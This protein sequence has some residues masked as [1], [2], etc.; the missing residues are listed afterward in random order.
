MEGDPLARR[1]AARLQAPNAST[2]PGNGAMSGP[3]IGSNDSLVR[4]WSAKCLAVRRVTQ[5]NR[6]KRTAG[7]DGVKSL[8][9]PQRLQLVRTLQLPQ[10]ARP[11]RRV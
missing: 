9:P 3:S 1:R 8:T 2:K 6:G 11:T 7:I 5:E 10:R 4:S